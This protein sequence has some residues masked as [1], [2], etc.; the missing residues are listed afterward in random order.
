MEKLGCRKNPMYNKF[1]SIPAKP[2]EVTT[3][4]N[5]GFEK[6]V[7]KEF[8]TLNTVFS[9][10]QISAA[11]TFLLWVEIESNFFCIV[12]VDYLTIS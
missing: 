2:V 7:L 3:V 9:K 6:I 11:I 4:Q 1:G 8:P 10:F 12:L 5:F